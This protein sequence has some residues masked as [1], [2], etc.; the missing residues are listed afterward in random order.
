VISVDLTAEQAGRLTDAGV[1]GA[2]RAGRTRLSFFLYNT[3]EDVDL[4]LAST[5]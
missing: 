1:V 2:I 4:V 5:R 3:M